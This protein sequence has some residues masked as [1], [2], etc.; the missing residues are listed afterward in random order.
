MLI[1]IAELKARFNINIKG[2]LHIGAH[3]CEELGDYISGGVNLSNI[4]WIEALPRLVEKNKRSNPLLNIYQAVIYDED[5]KEIEFNIT[6]CDGDVN[7]FASSSILEFG[8]HE[9]SHPQVRVVDKVKMKTSRM[10]SVINK[11]AINMKNVN[12]INLDIQGVELHALKSMESYLNNID[13]IY[14]E[15]NTEEV[16]KNC[17]QMADLTT[18]L[19]E[20]NFRLADA[21]IYKQFGWGDAFY[22]KNGL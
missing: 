11:Y 22:I 14:S 2:I 7:N 6:N 10:D 9:T 20:H 3:N 15:V 8:S 1:T 4:Y 19:A 18:Y 5:D 13:Y 21:R 16:Y 17:D 12:F